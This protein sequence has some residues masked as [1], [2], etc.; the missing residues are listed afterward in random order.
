MSGEFEKINWEIYVDGSFFN[1]CVGYGAAILKNGILEQEIKG[2]IDNEEYAAV[3]QVGGEMTAVVMALRWCMSNNVQTVK[4]YYDFANLKKWAT[5]EYQA[6]HPLSIRYREFVKGCP[7]QVE[8]IKVAG[9]S[10]V[11]WNEYVDRLAKSA[12]TGNAGETR[13]TPL[14]QE[15]E[16]L[17]IGLSR[18]LNEEGIE[19][20][21]LGIFNENCGRIEIKK[22][23][24]R[25][26]SINLYNTE[27]KRKHLTWHEMKKADADTLERLKKLA[28]M[29]LK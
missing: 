9:H 28:V 29:Y 14:Q 16:E 12:I 13:I 11:E 7:V 10:G 5:G 27:K 20:A 1:G 23:N 6:K 2:S 19:A 24:K 15:L 8:W 26:G 22:A 18:F 3:R 25:L 17:C 21:F 4:M